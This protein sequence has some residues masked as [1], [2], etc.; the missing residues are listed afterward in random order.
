[1][2]MDQFFSSRQPLFGRAT[3][4]VLVDEFPADELKGFLPKY[5]PDQ[6]AQTAAVIGGVA[7]YLSLWNDAVPPLKNIEDL[8]LNAA[9][10]FRH[11]A[12]FLIQ[13]ELPEPKTYLA[14]L[15]ALEALEA[16]GG[17]HQ[18]PIAISKATGFDSG[19]V[20]KYLT[21]HIFYSSAAP[22]LNGFVSRTPLSPVDFDSQ[23]NSIL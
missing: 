11:E 4:S 3:T 12:L 1:M 2:M 15:E 18:A 16:L 6:I 14:I 10:L 8:V 13:E 22:R 19:H 7:H 23:S 17:Q 9:T 5:S 20:G 21:T